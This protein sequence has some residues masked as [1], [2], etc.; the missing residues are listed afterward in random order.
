[1]TPKQVKGPKGTA[2]VAAGLSNYPRR[3]SATIINAK[4]IENQKKYLIAR[5]R[6][7]IVVRF[8]L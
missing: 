5:T 7:F 2:R 8:L 4:R 6:Y 1:M 3:T